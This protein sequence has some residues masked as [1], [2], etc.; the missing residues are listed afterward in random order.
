MASNNIQV[1][2][3]GVFKDALKLSIKKP[4]IAFFFL[5]TIF[6]QIKSQRRRLKLIKN[7]IQ[8]PPVMIFSITNKCNLKCKGCYNMTLRPSIKSE[9]NTDEVAS[10]LEQAREVGMSFIVVAGGEPFV[11]KDFLKI[12]KAFPELVFLVFT[13]SLLIDEATI[14]EIKKQRNVIPVLSIEGHIKQT[15]NRRGDGVFSSVRTVIE[16]LKRESIFFGISFTM[17]RQN[18]NSI[19]DESFVRDLVNQG[20]KLFFY[21]EYT[22]ITEGTEDWIIKKEQRDKIPGIMA[23]YRKRFPSLFIGIPAEE[24][25]FGGCLSSG[26]GF[27]H[28]NAEGGLEPCPFAPFSDTSLKDMPLKDALKSKLLEEIRNNLHKLDESEGG[29]SLWNNREWIQSL[30]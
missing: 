30:L 19:T 22:A 20:S 15:D 5:K 9:L 17:T 29:C 8:V 28:V 25:A 26:R 1:S 7:G 11:R 18:F 4:S 6:N 23:E 13:N 16:N 21:L 12:T 27:I 3:V 14:D 10:I 2:T 24:E